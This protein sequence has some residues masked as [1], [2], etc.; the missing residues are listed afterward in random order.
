MKKV[1]SNHPP[2][3]CASLL[4]FVPLQVSRRCSLNSTARKFPGL[5]PRH[6][7][8]DK[9]L[10]RLPPPGI[11]LGAPLLSRDLITRAPGGRPAPPMDRRVADSGSSG[12]SDTASYTARPGL[13]SLSL[14]SPAGRRIGRRRVNVAM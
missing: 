6:A 14:W 1:F 12:L 5:A 11:S 7:L 8:V 9:A 10:S 3:S 4:Y 2:L 13:G